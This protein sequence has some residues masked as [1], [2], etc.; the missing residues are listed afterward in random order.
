MTISP[1][2]ASKTL[3]RRPIAT[4]GF[5]LLRT[6][7]SILN[8]AE[9]LEA[10]R[11]RYGDIYL[12][13]RAGFAPVVIVSHPEAIAQ[14]LTADPDRFEVGS[15]NESLEPLL[16]PQ[17]LVLLDGADHA[18]TRKLLM[19]PFHGE[20]LRSYGNTIATLARDTF[21]EQPVGE[22]WDVRAT[23]QTI[24]LRT[25]LHVVFGVANGDRYETLRRLLAQW[26]DIFS[27]PWNAS[28]LLLPFLRRDLGPRSPWGRF[29]RLRDR[30]DELLYAEIRDRHG[31]RDRGEPTGHDILSLLMDARDEDGNPLSD[32]ELRDELL[33]LLF[34]G[35]ETTATSLTWAFYWLY[36][37]SEIRDRLA[38][39][40]DGIDP[41]KTPLAVTQLPYL[42]A[43]CNEALRLYTPA[44]YTFFRKP[45]DD[46]LQLMGYDIEQGCAIAPCI[47]LLHQRPDLYP[48]PREFRPERFLERQ[49][50]PYEFMP[51]GGSNRRCIGSALAQLEMKLVLAIASTHFNFAASSQEPARPARRGITLAPKTPVLLYRKA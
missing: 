2:P 11:D 25:I 17:S 24:T 50:S 14:L 8:P 42:N 22:Q 32:G 28:F 36:R 33:T 44:V 48:N 3:K 18:R 4:Q 39:E 37:H 13:R 29:L 35:H 16:G 5:P 10:S 31:V 38:A 6:I 46:N 20:R 34:A 9:F 43:V 30:I 21:N 49:F 7:R 41:I 12:T 19:P 26:L 27:S 51:F 23:M 47:Y 1:P 15:T 40:L 45:K